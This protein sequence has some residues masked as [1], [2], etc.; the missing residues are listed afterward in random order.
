MKKILTGSAFVLALVLGFS[1]STFAAAGSGCAAGAKFNPTTGQ[2]CATSQLITTDL[3]GVSSPQSSA[4]QNQKI[5]DATKSLVARMQASGQKVPAEL[6][7]VAHNYKGIF[8]KTLNVGS[9]D[10]EVKLL[11]KFLNLR[12]FTI[13]KT[14][15]GSPDNESTF[16]GPATQKALAKFQAANGISPASGLW[17]PMTR[18]RIESMSE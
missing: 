14:G 11:Q 16:F 10:N 1:H 6:K 18:A 13:A 17:G 15:V 9:K 3:A 5:V 4:L 8:T 7:L 12:G 2:P